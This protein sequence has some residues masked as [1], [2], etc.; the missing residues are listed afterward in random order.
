MF[1]MIVDK[2]F[3]TQLNQR[4]IPLLYVHIIFIYYTIFEQGQSKVVYYQIF[5]HCQREKFIK[6]LLLTLL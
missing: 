2:I 5:D 3:I 1:I 4:F 6:I